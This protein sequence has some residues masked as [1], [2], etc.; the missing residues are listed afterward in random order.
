MKKKRKGETV[1]MNE[2]GKRKRK[3]E[4]IK[5]KLRVKTN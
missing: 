3:I 2:K 4:L 1:R 5:R